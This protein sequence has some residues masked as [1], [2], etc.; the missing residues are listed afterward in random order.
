MDAIGTDMDGY[1]V[2]AALRCKTTGDVWYARVD[3]EFRRK[4]YYNPVTKDREDSK[5]PS[6]KTIKDP[7]AHDVTSDSESGIDDGR[8]EG[9][10]FVSSTNGRRY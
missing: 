6:W 9:E 8:N 1:E 4:H 10:S 7:N 3:K 2:V 5:W